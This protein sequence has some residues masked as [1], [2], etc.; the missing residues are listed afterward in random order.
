MAGSLRVLLI[1]DSDDDAQLILRELRRGGYGVE[2]ELVETQSEME[3][4]LSDRPW[5]LILSDYNMPLFNALQALETLKASGLDLPFIILSGTINEESAVTALKAGAHDFLLK[6]KLARL[7]PAIERELREVRVRRAHREAEAERESLI[8]KLA[9]TNAEL[10][11]FMY[12]AFHDLR[13]PLVTIKGFLGMLKSDLQSQ[14]QDRIEKDFERIAGAADKLDRLL[15]DLLELSRIE[16]V[17]NPL[18]EIDLCQLAQEVLEGLDGRIHSGQ[19]TVNISPDLP[20][21]YGD[22]VRIREVLLN[23]VDNAEK[24]TRGRPTP[25]IKIGTR[26]DDGERVI[27][28]QDNGPGIDPRY[29]TRIFNLFE[30]LDPT[31]EGTGLGLALTKRIVEIHGGRI[32]V[33]S[34]GQDQGSTF[35]FTLPDS[36]GQKD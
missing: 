30:K 24:Y 8:E 13:A 32:W 27:F 1:E 19:V 33:E 3:K 35:C 15:N 6:N 4:A 14:R 23:L 29:H 12:T 18:E 31:L 25:E 21:V 26:S 16:R 17:R 10:E 5:D 11:R 9:A 7:I 2:Y 22:R 20:T 34:T 28:V 36:R